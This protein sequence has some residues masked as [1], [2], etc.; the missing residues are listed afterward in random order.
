ML[1]RFDTGPLFEIPLSAAV[2]STGHWQPKAA[3][4]ATHNLLPD[5]ENE[6]KTHATD[7]MSYG[8]APGTRRLP[9]RRPH[10]PFM[11]GRQG[12]R[13]KVASRPG[14]EYAPVRP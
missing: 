6:E 10:N 12:V 2:A 7:C 8:F 9:S 13:L 5:L 3:A 4:S 11:S 14:R 1:E